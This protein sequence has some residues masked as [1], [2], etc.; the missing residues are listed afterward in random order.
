M[1]PTASCYLQTGNASAGAVAEMAGTRKASKYR[2]LVA[3]YI[4]QPVALKT[5]KSHKSPV[6]IE[7][8]LFCSSAFLFSFLSFKFGFELN[9]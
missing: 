5:H 7:R 9:D 2:E 4:F 6:A 8:F 3:Q 1:C